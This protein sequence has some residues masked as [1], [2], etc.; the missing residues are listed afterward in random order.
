MLAL[1]Y[2]FTDVQSD[3]LLG[4]ETLKQKSQVLFFSFT[5][6]VMNFI[7]ELHINPINNSLENPE[8]ILDSSSII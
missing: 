1:I 5:L 7:K 2:L 4:K 8:P 6:N 3:L